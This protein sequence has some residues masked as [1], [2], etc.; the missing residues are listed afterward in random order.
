MEIKVAFSDGWDFDAI[1]W[2]TE[3]PY[4]SI[5]DNGVYDRGVICSSLEKAIE[6]ANIFNDASNDA[7]EYVWITVDGKE[8]IQ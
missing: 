2:E 5:Y 1:I 7:S 4:D 6:V 3:A 8:Y